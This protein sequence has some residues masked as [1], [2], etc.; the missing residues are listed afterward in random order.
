MALDSSM[1]FRGHQGQY[2][3]HQ[4]QFETFTL[5]LTQLLSAFLTQL[6]FNWQHELSVSVPVIFSIY[7]YIFSMRLGILFVDV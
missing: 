3:G 4:G 1:F 2:A 6:V 7:M 5:S